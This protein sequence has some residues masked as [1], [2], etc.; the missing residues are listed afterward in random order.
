[1]LQLD[2]DQVHKAKFKNAYWDGWN[3]VVIKP[4]R[5]AYT[6]KNAVFKFGRWHTVMDTIAP[7]SNGI[8]NV[9]SDYVSRLV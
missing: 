5:S 4:N 1:M 7:D 2:Y 3:L 6:Q 9:R 8:W